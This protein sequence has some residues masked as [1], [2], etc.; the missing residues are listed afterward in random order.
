MKTAGKKVLVTGSHGFLGR[1][2]VE[3][4][5]KEGIP[6]ATYDRAHPEALP[7]GI[8]SVVHFAGITPASPGTH[9]LA[10]YRAANVEGTRQLLAA[11]SAHPRLDRFVNIGSCA[12]YGFSMKPLAE[13]ALERP[14]NDYGVS[15][16]E[17]SRLVEEFARGTGTPAINLRIFNVAGIPKRAASNGDRWR[18]FIFEVLIGQ[19]RAGKR[20]IQITN[21][22]D[23]RDY[24][25]IDD[26]MEAV[27][28]ALRMKRGGRFEIVNVCSGKGT[29]L[30]D[31]VGMFGSLM[32]RDFSIRED[33]K[34]PTV[35]MGD[36]KK[37]KAVLGWEAQTPLAESARRILTHWK[38]VL[39][40]GA[41]VA[42]DTVLKEIES[43]PDRGILPCG[44]VDDDPKKQ[45]TA[46]RGVHVLG[47]ISDIPHLIGTDEFDQVLISTPSVS[48][49]VD[50]VVAALPPGFPVKVLP[51]VSSV[52]LGSVD[53]A[54]VRDIDVSD[55][56]DRPLVKADQVRIRKNVKSKT[57]LVTGAAGSIG[58]EIVRQL[59]DSG[60]KRVVAFDAWEE[61]VFNL[62]E[63]FADRIKS[64][65]QRFVAY[66]GNTRDATR[67][68]EVLRAERIDAIIH[69]AAYK[70][71]PLMEENPEEARKTN[72]LGTKNMLDAAVRHRVRDFV[73]ISTDKAVNP[74]SVMGKSKRDAEL[75]MKRYAK[76][77]PTH[78]FCAVRFGNVLNSSG[79]VIPTFL[80]QIRAG[81]PVTVTDFRMTRYFMSIPEAVSL[82]LQAWIVAK[83]GQ[84]LILDMG[85]PVRILDLALQL[86]RLHGLEPYA[87]I[88]IREIGARPGE[89]IHEELTYD[90]GKIRQ[91]PAARVFIGEE[92]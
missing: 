57:F 11:L 62:R 63:E 17:Q 54:R 58:S 14:T 45:G 60:A 56:I 12:E 75:L 85:E 74:S 70:H 35:S 8:S 47:A 83:N 50:R 87:D 4:L 82:V 81:A 10:D 90:A 21:R 76:R 5:K 68:G 49:L 51:S 48:G 34:A 46:L 30:S 55:L 41:G 22:N 53:L 37:A 26:A 84:I 80:R 2:F 16:L 71:V 73:L 7:D 19:F 1:A 86:I 77:H 31:L 20:A 64:K 3:K 66:I 39:I 36:S 42:G 43:S 69:A 9:T 61:G 15:K 23:I 91:S 40:V 24:V 13:D 88:P 72:V 27:L 44:I 29:A 89:K 79:S 65:G 32:N 52:I 28:A 38:R 78:R 67:I 25:D 92:L 6:F 33:A 59:V 18:P